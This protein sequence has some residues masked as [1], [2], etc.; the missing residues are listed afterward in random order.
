M[1]KKLKSGQIPGKGDYTER[2]RAGTPVKT[3]TLDD[4]T[5]R[6]PPTEKKGRHFT[7]D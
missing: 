3:V 4:S 7:K 2:T 6:L 1:A 5:D